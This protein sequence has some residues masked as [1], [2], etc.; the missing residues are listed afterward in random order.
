M[1][2]ET[3]YASDASFDSLARLDRTAEEP[4]LA[5]GIGHDFTGGKT[6]E[7]DA[8]ARGLDSRGH[9][10]F[11]L[12]PDPVHHRPCCERPVRPPPATQFL[13][14]LG[15]SLDEEAGAGK[16]MRGEPAHQLFGD[17]GGDE[18]HRVDLVDW[19]VELALDSEIGR[20]I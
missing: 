13:G 18:G 15:R 3:L 11:E 12:P 6:D 16:A 2:K 20:R 19:G 1:P 17:A 5:T 8:C 7:G 9:P 10:S 4:E 14:M